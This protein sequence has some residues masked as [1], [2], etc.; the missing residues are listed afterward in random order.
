MQVLEDWDQPRPAR[1]GAGA[2]YYPP[3]RFTD[4][5]NLEGGA[6]PARGAPAGAGSAV[7]GAAF[8]G[9]SSS[10]AAP[11]STSASAATAAAAPLAAPCGR[12]GATAGASGGGGADAGRSLGGG[13]FCGPCGSDALGGAWP[14]GHSAGR[15]TTS[16]SGTNGVSSGVINGESVAR[17][18]FG[19][20]SNGDHRTSS[21]AG[22]FGGRAAASCGG[23]VATNGSHSTASGN[24]SGTLIT[25][26]G[27]VGGTE[28]DLGGGGA[29]F[30]GSTDFGEARSAG[31]T[32][33]Y[34]AAAA[35]AS[36]RSSSAAAVAAPLA[37]DVALSVQKPVRP[38]SLERLVADAGPAGGE[39]QPSAATGSEPTVEVRGGG[40]G[41][42]LPGPW[43]SWADVDFPSRVR[44]PLLSAGFPAP[45]LI[46]QHAWPI[47]SLGRDL[48]GVAKT[49]SGKTLAFLLPAFSRL[50]EGRADLRGPPA[51][52][53]L[54]P[55]REL[56]CQIEQEA[57]G[58]GASAGMRAVCLY[59]GAPKGPQLAE[60]RQRPQ[61]VVATPGRL[62]DLLD[63]SPGLSLAVDVKSV[64]YLVLDEADRM[65]DMGFE[66]QIR[67]IIVGLPQD[68]QTVLFTATW[69]PGVRRMA[70]DF[71]RNPVEVRVGEVDHL[72]VNR[73]IEQRVVFCE[74]ALDKEE[75]LAETLREFPTEQAIVFVNTKR[76]CEVVAMRIS[77]SVSIHGDKDQRERDMALA[78][79][80][81]GSKRVL[82]ATDVAA[83][84][85]DV[86]S[87]KLVVNFD[88]PNK[89][90][91]YVHRVGRTGRA[92]K[93]GTAVALLTNDDGT[94]A[95]FI[96]DLLKRA[97]LPVPEELSRRLASGEMRA[98]SGG[99]RDPSRGPRSRGREPSRGRS[100]GGRGD[101]DFGFLPMDDDFG[102]SRRPDRSALLA[103]RDAGRRDNIMPT[104]ND[105]P[106]W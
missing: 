87:V 81:S 9:S 66:P 14:N 33:A 1:H 48:V 78:A 39:P 70:A 41:A 82:V 75:R 15:A 44:A 19:G 59:G 8:G 22:S 79:F 57:R 64:R 96:A 23:Y 90:E 32:S 21:G 99:G 62:N 20:I 86:K 69:P 85:L 52:L 91:D 92:G 105:C 36:A 95:R 50:L 24:C 77:N 71:Q 37:S 47:L 11:A 76:M 97:G 72:Q 6:E 4:L 34:G 54:A 56:A 84:G 89:D 18:S 10:S 5:A 93:K 55:T 80:K 103:D 61:V 74:H 12:T 42:E 60:L 104:A 35:G 51:I 83:R 102:F 26:T 17:N 13:D 16:Y 49:G 58:F 25:K 67:K 31:G 63:P 3:L 2:S 98:S 46:Q 65:L 43:C 29:V 73:D 45:T 40:D 53:V 101:D 88:P 100:F 106:T 68:R 28:A 30:R 27:G 38:R 94:A 7:L